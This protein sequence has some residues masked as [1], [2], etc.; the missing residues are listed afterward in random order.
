VNVW[1]DSGSSK[2]SGW[3]GV[4]NCSVRTA[5][6]ESCLI[7]L[8]KDWILHYNNAIAN[9]EA[10]SLSCPSIAK[11]SAETNAMC[12]VVCILQWTEHSHKQLF[13][14]LND[15]AASLQRLCSWNVNVAASKT[16]HG[17]ESLV[18]HEANGPMDHVA[19]CRLVGSCR[20]I[21]CLM[22]KHWTC[23]PR[24]SKII[25]NIYCFFKEWFVIFWLFNN[26]DS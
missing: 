11:C 17:E 26:Y 8:G 20:I 10:I 24:S 14:A 13:Q 23:N 22:K 21:V 15:S 18:K 5:I 4:V 12:H 9:Y 25:I 19:S 7:W 2:L 3:N 6:D 16:H 1:L